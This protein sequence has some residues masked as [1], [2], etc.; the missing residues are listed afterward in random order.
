MT[1]FRLTAVAGLIGVLLG[2][3]PTLAQKKYDEGADDAE[4]RI[5]NTAPYSGPVSSYGASAMA[6]AAYFRK[7]NDEGGINGRKINFISVDDSYS[8]PKTVEVVRRLVEQD[9]VLLIFGMAGTAPASAVQKYLNAKKVPQLFVYSGASKWGDPKNY[10][11]T[12]GWYPDYGSEAVA[13]AK[14]IAATTKDPKIGILY[15]NDDLGKDYKE[16]MRRGLG[17]LADKAIVAEVSYEPSAPTIDSELAQLKASGADVLLIAAVGRAATQAV[18]RSSEMGWL[19]Q[20]V[21]IGAASNVDAILRPAGL[22]HGTGLISTTF[23]KDAGMPH[24]ADDPGVRDWRAWM[25][26]YAPDASPANEFYNT[27]Y[28]MA[29]TMVEVLRRCGDDLTR[30]NVMKQ[31]ASLDKF[32]LPLLLPEVTLSTS[33]TDF[34]PIQTFRMTRFD[35]EKW[36]VFGDPIGADPR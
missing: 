6:M 31:A 36:V 17:A 35:G 10:P 25:A 2:A 13:F 5:G 29:Q 7:I 24:W 9:K 16:G 3:A 21:L 27:G 18:R 8:P 23:R 14:H 4:I 26:K 34:Y 15:Q 11:W 33:P 19:G 12:M 32:P 22:N 20:R 1:F 30:A 28:S